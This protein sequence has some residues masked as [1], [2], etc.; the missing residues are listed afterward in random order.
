MLFDK[1][2]E[3]YKVLM[4]DLHS[5]WSSCSYRQCLPAGSE[6]LFRE[7]IRVIQ[8]HWNAFQGAG[9]MQDEKQ[10]RYVVN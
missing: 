7:N 3:D 2:M 5:S 8:G 1:C 10:V 6:D 4:K 9:S